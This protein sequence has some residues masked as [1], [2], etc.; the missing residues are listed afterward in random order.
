[1]KKWKL[2]LFAGVLTAGG[3]FTASSVAQNW[4]LAY[5][6][7]EHPCL[8]WRVYLIRLTD[9]RPMRDQIVTFHAQ[10]VEPF[11]PNGTLFTKL[12]IGLPGETVTVGPDS[13]TV[14]GVMHPGLSR[15]V[16]QKLGKSLADFAT[17]YTLGPDEFFMVGTDPEAFDSRYYGPVKGSRV[18]G[19]ARPLW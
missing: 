10:G 14:G 1:M 7:A 11:F 8:P 17:T 4:R 19:H 15:A 6:K 18:F 5:D 2:L 3:A 16:A 12:V 9:D 13:V